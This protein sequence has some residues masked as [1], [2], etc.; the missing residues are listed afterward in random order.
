[1]GADDTDAQVGETKSQDNLADA[2][3]RLLHRADS[4]IPNAN[5]KRWQSKCDLMIGSCPVPGD[6][7]SIA[8]PV[9]GSPGL[10]MLVTQSG[11]TLA[12]ALGRLLAETIV[13][14]HPNPQLTAFDP[15]RFF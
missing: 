6:G 4:L 3:S 14:A 13:L 5:T 8:G 7:Y 9:P 11:V 2:A 1:M 12:P 10:Y 15:S